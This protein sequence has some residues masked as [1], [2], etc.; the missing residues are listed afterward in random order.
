MSM[1]VGD[2]HASTIE[3]GSEILYGELASWWPLLSPPW[4]YE[5]EAGVYRSMFELAC[6]DAA[7][8]MLEL[9]SGGGNNAAFL[10][11]RFDM[12]LVDLSPAMLE[13]SRE[14]NPE[15][16]HVQGDMRTIRLD[17]LFDCVFI[18]DAIM[19]MSTEQELKQAMETAFVH[20]RPGG[21]ALFVTDFVRETFKAGTD[22]GGYDDGTQGLRYME[23]TWD[24]DPD[25]TSYLVD[26]AYLLRHE[27]GQVQ[28]AH[29]RH[30]EG[31]FPRQTWL[32]LMTE[33]GFQARRMLIEPGSGLEPGE[34]EIFLGRKPE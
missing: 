15:C 17:R 34:C 6:G 1:G 4:E 27:D 12:T 2:Q 11:R 5:G 26:Y 7:K 9:G 8:T 18:H 31:L 20:C 33:V 30:L 25:D 32:D 22:H 14:L 10:N 3:N 29:D 24:P 23:W 13:V 21:V 19:Y 28:V 16:E